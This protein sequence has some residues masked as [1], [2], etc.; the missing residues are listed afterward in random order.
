MNTIPK[1]IIHWWDNFSDLIAELRWGHS[2]VLGQIYFWFRFNA[3]AIWNW[4]E[5]TSILCLQACCPTKPREDRPLWTGWRCST[6]S[7]YP[8]TRWW[9]Q[10]KKKRPHCMLCDP[11]MS[12]LLSV[13]LTFILTYLVWVMTLKTN[14]LWDMQA[15]QCK[16]ILFS[17]FT[18]FGFV[19]TEEAHGCSSCS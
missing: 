5:W 16:D 19:S 3:L 11:D 17:S 10:F 1:L 4:I 7:P 2:C 6:V 8:M 13:M 14:S 15:Y 12:T 18:D 9:S